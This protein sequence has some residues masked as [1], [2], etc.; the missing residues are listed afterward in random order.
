MLRLLPARLRR[1]RVVVRDIK[2][3][4]LLVLVR[5]NEFVRQVVI[6][7]I[8]TH[9]DSGSSNYSRVLGARLRFRRKNF[10]NKIQ[11]GLI[12]T[13]ASQK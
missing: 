3:L 2:P 5:V 12:P 10:Q 13:K 6:S 1:L 9:L 7:G 11:W 4:G 8:F